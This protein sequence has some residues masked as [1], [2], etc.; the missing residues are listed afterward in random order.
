MIATRFADPRERPARPV[1]AF[2][3]ALS[4]SFHGLEVCDRNLLRFHYFHR[5]TVGQLSEMFWLQPSAMVRQL[6]RI[7]ERLL[8]DTR[9]RLARLDKRELD[10]LLE[11]AHDRFDLMLMRVLRERE[12][13]VTSASR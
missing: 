10:R 7:R 13:P 12:R 6:A 4:E 1:D 9:R 2:C 3:D 8:R 11:L 5:L